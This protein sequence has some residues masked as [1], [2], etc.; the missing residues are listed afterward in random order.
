MKI[1]LLEPI[2]I[3]GALMDE[4]SAPLKAAGHEFVFYPEKTTD[5]SELYERA[6]DSDIVMIANNPLPNEVIEKCE[7]LKMLDVAFTGI[8]H[9]GLKACAEKGVMVC[10]AA[11]YSNETVSELADKDQRGRQSHKGRKNHGFRRTY[12]HGAWNKDRGNN[13]NRK[14]RHNDS[15]TFQSV[16]MPPS[17]IQQKRE[18]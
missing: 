1:S 11:G 4:L 16:R 8:D 2:G 5:P 13:R 17:W 9:V 7:K 3:D 14:D 18:G 12:G 10:N 15:Q 6:K